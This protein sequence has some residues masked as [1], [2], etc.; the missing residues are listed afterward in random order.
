MRVLEVFP[1]T[2]DS[3]RSGVASTSAAGHFVAT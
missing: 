3:S 1:S 2:C